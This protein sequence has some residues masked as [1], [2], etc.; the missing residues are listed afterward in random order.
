MWRRRR[1]CAFSHVVPLPPPPFTIVTMIPPLGHQNG[2]WHSS[3]MIY[4]VYYYIREQSSE[5]TV[6]KL[7]GLE[8]ITG[9]STNDVLFQFSLAIDEKYTR[10][11]RE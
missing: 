5:K 1:R 10:C 7:I 9:S 4:C 11:R 2:L 8:Q 3:D 6:T